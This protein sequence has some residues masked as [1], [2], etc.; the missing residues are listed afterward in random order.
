MTQCHFAAILRQSCTLFSGKDIFT[1]KTQE[2][3]NLTD[4]VAHVNWLLIIIEK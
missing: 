3:A 1:A 2:I 4:L